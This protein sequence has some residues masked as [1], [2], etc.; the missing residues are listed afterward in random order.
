MTVYL[1]RL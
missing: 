1:L